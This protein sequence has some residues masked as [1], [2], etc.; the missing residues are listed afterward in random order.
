MQDHV[1]HDNDGEFM[2][3]HVVKCLALS[4]ARED[5]EYRAVRELAQRAIREGAEKGAMSASVS[6]NNVP[7]AVAHAIAEELN[8][9]GYSVNVYGQATAYR[10]MLSLEISWMDANATLARMETTNPDD[11]MQ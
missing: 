6:I 7:Q 2:Q 3:A 11:M 1:C 8:E 9:A 5:A 4:K 10:T